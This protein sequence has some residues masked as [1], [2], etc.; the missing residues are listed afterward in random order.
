MPTDPDPGPRNEA[1]GPDTL[2]PPEWVEPPFD[3]PQG[4]RARG[5]IAARVGH[6]LARG[7]DA[8]ADAREELL[9]E[10]K[11]HPLAFG[12]FI[13]TLNAM[14]EKLGELNLVF[15][16]VGWWWVADRVPDL[17]PTASSVLE[18][19]VNHGWR[20]PLLIPLRFSK[21]G[22]IDMPAVLAEVGPFDRLRVAAAARCEAVSMAARPFVPP[23]APPP[24]RP[25]DVADHYVGWANGTHRPAAGP[26]EP[27]VPTPTQRAVLDA[28]D[29]RA[30]RQT[31]LEEVTRVD[32]AMLHRPTGLKGL[33]AAGLVA[34]HPRLGY[35]R[36]DCPPPD[37]APPGPPAGG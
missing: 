10:A 6:E 27:F 7:V 23:V 1:P 12:A 14:G 18:A 21:D 31:R 3:R 24:Y 29:G 37:L 5:R 9:R 28:L 15:A 22:R 4:R 33:R 19:V 17:D 8:I 13:P 16:Q 35:Y 32:R 20:L 30:L 11:V 34:H 25:D 26:A 36:P 2:R